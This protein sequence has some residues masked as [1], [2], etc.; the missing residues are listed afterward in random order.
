MC[1]VPSQLSLGVVS[2]SYGGWD[3]HNNEAAEIGANLA[4]VFGT[5][6]GLDTALTAIENLPYVD[7]PASEN[8]AFYFAS[9]FGRQIVAN[10]AA[11]TD[12]GSGT[13]TMV[14]GHSIRG[15]LYG[16]LFP[17]RESRPDTD[18]Q[19]PLETPGAEIEGLTA[20]DRILSRVADWV[21]QGAGEVVFP[22]SS[23]GG[24]ETGVSFANLFSD[25][26]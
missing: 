9:D 2:M 24:R 6:G 17:E 20:T 3:T 10:G 11:G 12:H 21:N 15:G 5:G 13:Y 7:V 18:S 22:N 14:L 8:L 25:A 19:I 16:E 23:A 1:Q 26:G 4:D